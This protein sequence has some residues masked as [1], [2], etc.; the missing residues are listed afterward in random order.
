MLL[1]ALSVGGRTTS[2]YDL[3]ASARAAGYARVAW[4]A[5]RLTSLRAFRGTAVGQR[6]AKPPIVCAHQALADPD[7]SQQ[8]GQRRE[9]SCPE[10]RWRTAR[11]R[12]SAGA[13]SPYRPR[14]ARS[15]SRDGR[16]SRR[17][18]H[19]GAG[20]PH[21]PLAQSHG[22]ARV[23]TGGALRRGLRVS[24]TSAARR[25]FSPRPLRKSS[26][27]SCETTLLSSCRAAPLRA[28]AYVERCLCDTA[29]SA[30]MRDARRRPRSE[31]SSRVT[32]PDSS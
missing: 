18:R 13:D 24:C 21:M 30:L 12:P 28:A 22:R 8:Q 2:L 29:T 7:W 25:S 32:P 3:S 16:C 15:G 1:P 9:D 5:L 26:D 6:L 4:R 27:G 11:S 20:G 31:R 10:S 19:G 17:D 14:C 23:P